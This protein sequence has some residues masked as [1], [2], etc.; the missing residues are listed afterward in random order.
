M[1]ETAAVPGNSD[2]TG[3]KKRLTDETLLLGHVSLL[4]TLLLSKDDKYVIT[5]DR[6]EH[7]RVSWYPEAYTIE[8]YCLG[9]RK[10]GLDRA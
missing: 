6:D 5:A 4:T 2:I 8:G 9:H 10:Y 3:T 1:K 7:I